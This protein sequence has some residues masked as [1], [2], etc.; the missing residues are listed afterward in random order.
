MG[1]LCSKSTAMSG[2]HQI[3]GSSTDTAPADH[4][5]DRRAAAAEAAERRVKAEQGRGT[6]ATN[7]KQGVLAAKLSAS[8]SGN[9]ESPSQLPERVV[10]D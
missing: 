6:Q 10:W 9:A 4:P 7:P 5:V 3:L 8:K 1:S 2:G